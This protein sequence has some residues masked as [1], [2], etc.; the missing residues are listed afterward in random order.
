MPDEGTRTVVDVRE[1]D[2]VRYVPERQSRWC[3]ECL[4]VAVMWSGRLVLVDTF[5]G[6]RY[7]D[8]HVLTDAEA[9]TA[10]LVF[11]TDDY[12]ELP[13]YGGG[14]RD[15]W[16]RYAPADRE[17][18]TSQHGL[19]ARWFIPPWLREQRNDWTN[20]RSS[21][22]QR[23]QGRGRRPPTT[24]FCPRRRDCRATH[25]RANWTPP[26]RPV[27][28]A[29]PRSLLLLVRL[30]R[31]CSGWCGGRPTPYKPPPTKQRSCAS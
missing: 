6:L 16:E 14:S 25:Y 1:N 7:S 4:A 13:Q 24:A 26:R 27:R 28:L 12:D 19:Q 23:R 20:C 10:E 31:G 5:W 11:N 29:M 21:Q 30:F 15:L 2:V 8:D 3:R 18:I 9:S 17:R 22:R